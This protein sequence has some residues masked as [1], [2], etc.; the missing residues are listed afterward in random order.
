[1]SCTA[2]SVERESGL[3][4]QRRKEVFMDHLSGIN[5]WIRLLLPN[6]PVRSPVQKGLTW[7]RNSSIGGGKDLKFDVDMNQPNQVIQCS[8]GCENIGTK[9]VDY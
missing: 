3:E 8:V 2:N 5:E 9:P 7:N 6:S 1:M 4:W